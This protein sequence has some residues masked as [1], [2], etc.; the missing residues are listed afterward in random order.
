MCLAILQRQSSLLS[1]TSSSSKCCARRRHYGGGDWLDVRRWTATMTITMIM[2]LMMIILLLSEDQGVTAFSFPQTVSRSSQTWAALGNHQNQHRYQNNVRPTYRR[3]RRHGDV[4]PL[5]GM[6]PGILSS[7]NPFLMASADMAQATS[8]AAALGSSSSSSAALWTLFWETVITSSIPALFGLVTIAIAA[9]VFR[10][11]RGSGGYY[12]DG[13]DEFDNEYKRLEESV[14]GLQNPAAALYEDLYADQDQYAQAWQE[15]FRNSL[16]FIIY[17][18]YPATCARV[19]R[20]FA[21]YRKRRHRGKT[22]KKQ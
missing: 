21:G 3:C 16:L 22:N 1:S 8:S 18:F 20:H 15:R 2:M 4:L 13:D 12:D 17:F 14:F 10:P 7:S 9:F 19:I 5:Y 6:L 11:R